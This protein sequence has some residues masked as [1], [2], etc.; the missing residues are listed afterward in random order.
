LLQRARRAQGPVLVRGLDH[1][2]GLHDAARRLEAEQ[3][4]REERAFLLHPRGAPAPHTVPQS[5]LVVKWL[6]VPRVLDCVAPSSSTAAG[7]IR[8]M[9]CPR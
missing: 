8:A 9:L 2:L 3:R 5:W 4:A 7:Q 1:H 6:P